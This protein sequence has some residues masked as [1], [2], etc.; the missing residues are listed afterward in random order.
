MSERDVEIVRRAF[1]VFQDGNDRGDPAAAFDLEIT[2]P[3]FEWIV[4]NIAPGLRPV[5]RGR[6]GWLQFMHDWTDDFVWSIEIEEI[7][8]LGDGRVV[9]NTVQHATGKG[10]GVPVE[11][12][13]GAIWTVEG[14]QVSSVVNYLDPAEAFEA[15][16]VPE[17]AA[18][19]ST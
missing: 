3:D 9:V 18:D 11:L 13:M 12:H 4:P 7:V 15:A 14:G 19:G 16:G 17:S 2:H 6:E 5:Y 8:D 1:A 10:S